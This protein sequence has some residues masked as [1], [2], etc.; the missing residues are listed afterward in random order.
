MLTGP[1][2]E[3]SGHSALSPMTSSKSR[4]SK[5]SNPGVLVGLVFSDNGVA[6]RRTLRTAEVNMLEEPPQE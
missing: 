3:F 6:N 5:R 1:P 2:A 4:M